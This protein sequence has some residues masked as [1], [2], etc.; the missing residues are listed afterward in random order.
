M[1]AKNFDLVK[2]TILKWYDV[3]AETY[4]VSTLRPGS[5]MNFSERLADHIARW[6]KAADDID[7][8]EL[9][10]LEQFHQAL[11]RDMAVRVSEGKPNTPGIRDG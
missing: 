11:T 8:R 6:E 1:S 9:V 10:L 5:L 3:S 4:K 2:A 7:M